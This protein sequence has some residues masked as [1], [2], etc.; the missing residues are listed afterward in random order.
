MRGSSPAFGA[1]PAGAPAVIRRLDPVAWLLLAVAGWAMVLV[2]VV[3]LGWGGRSAP[4][5]DDPALAPKLPPVPHF[6]SGSVLKP[7]DAY[8]EA[9]N[10]PLFFPNRKPGNA[11][12]PGKNGADAHPLDVILTSVIMTDNLQM[13][14]VQDPKSHQSL[15]VREGQPIGGSYQGWTLTGLSPRSADFDGG[16]QG[17]QTLE[18]RVFDGKGGEEPTRMGLTPQAVAAGVLGNPSR[19]PPPVAPPPSPEDAAN[20]SAGA[21]PAAD[22]DANAGNNDE[23]AA[24]QAE[25]IRRR[26]EQRRQQLQQR[27]QANDRNP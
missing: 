16:S 5:A 24:R 18:L 10:H 21:A 23:A 25:E 13:A 6:A 9:F 1:A 15:R 2:A 27:R 14:I 20:D 26:I 4:L 17:Q 11:R 7:L 3:L 22:S 19:P 12:V 8:G